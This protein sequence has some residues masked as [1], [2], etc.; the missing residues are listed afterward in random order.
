MFFTTMRYINRHYLSICLS[1]YR[2]LTASLAQ[3]GQILGQRDRCRAN[4][5]NMLNIMPTLQ[6]WGIK[7]VKTEFT[8]K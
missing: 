8:K 2:L 5:K 4:G 6:T 1:I 3:D 7:I